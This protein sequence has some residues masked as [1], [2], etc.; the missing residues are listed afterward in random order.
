[1][2]KECSPRISNTGALH[3]SPNGLRACL[4][5][6]EGSF[7]SFFEPEPLIKLLGLKLSDFDEMKKGGNGY[8]KGMLFGHIRILYDGGADMGVH[9]SFSGQGCREYERVGAYSWNELLCILCG[10]GAGF[11][12]I[13]LAID[14]FKPYFTVK[15][16]IDKQMKEEYVSKWRNWDF[17]VR[18]RTSTGITGMTT[19]FGERT[20]RVMLRIYDKWKERVYDKGKDVE[21]EQWI[22]TEVE[23]HDA[24]ADLIAQRIASGADD[25]YKII[26]AFLKGYLRFVVKGKDSNKARWKICS[27]WEKFLADVDKLKMTE[28]A[29]DKSIESKM[30]WLKR[31]AEISLASIVDALGGDT[32]FL[33]EMIANGRK[34]YRD[35]DKKLID[36][37]KTIHGVDN[38]LKKKEQ[39]RK[40][41]LEKLKGPKKLTKEEMRK[42]IRDSDLED[43][44][45]A[46][47]KQAIVREK[48][49]RDKENSDKPFDY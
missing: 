42:I 45:N 46:L 1:M 36:E 18:G 24:R 22:R 2:S 23:F 9:F 47:H 34:R 5:W 43:K 41:L 16:I 4:D 11:S 17:R 26:S 32:D 31:Q 28:V 37:Y 29:P 6:V 35:K 27:W 38:D 8:R 3:T 49:L 12:R 13:D 33:F 30:L 15:Q 48:R 44:K 19:T 7:T 20:S 21:V 39:K 40:I 10:S 25:V 14:D